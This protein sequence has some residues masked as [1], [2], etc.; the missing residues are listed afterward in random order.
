MHRKHFGPLVDFCY[1]QLGE[2]NGLEGPPTS[3]LYSHFNKS[4][5]ENSAIFPLILDRE[6][7]YGI[8]VMFVNMALVKCQLLTKL[9]SACG[10]NKVVKVLGRFYRKRIISSIGPNVIKPFPSVIY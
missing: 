4:K 5:I 8:L 7:Y 3:S 1:D 6:F 2:L 9:F 10:R